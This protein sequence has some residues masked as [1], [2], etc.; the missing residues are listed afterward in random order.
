MSDPPRPRRRAEP[1]PGTANRTIRPSRSPGRRFRQQPQHPLHDREIAEQGMAAGQAGA[2]VVHLHVREDNG[3]QRTARA[4]PGPSRG[5]PRAASSITNVSTRRSNEMTIE[6]R[7]RPDRH[8]DLSGVESGSMDSGDDVHQASEGRARDHRAATG[9]R[10][11]LEVEAFDVGPA[12]AA[13]RWRRS[14]PGL[15]INLVFG[16]PGGMMPSPDAL[17]RDPRPLPPETTWT[18][19]LRGTP[20]PAD[21]ARWPCY[22]RARLPHRA[23]GCGVPQPGGLAKPKSGVGHGGD[24]LAQSF[25]REVASQERRGVSRPR[26]G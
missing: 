20:P 12:T 14:D 25:R 19:H 3:R 11:G 4:V 21:A 6:E 7:D 13:A 17:I 9:P 16:V 26:A 10:I 1:T 2:T 15:R 23:R 22:R 5:S 18:R 8:P 24:R